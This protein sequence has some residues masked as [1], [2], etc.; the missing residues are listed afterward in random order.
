MQ[1]VS[2]E[3]LK[4]ELIQLI[5]KCENEKALEQIYEIAIRIM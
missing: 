1:G 5:E 2:K 4:Q 3:T